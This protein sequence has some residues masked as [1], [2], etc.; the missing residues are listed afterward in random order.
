MRSARLAILPLLYAEMDRST[1][2]Q[3]RLVR[4]EEA[5]LM[6]NIP[7]WEVGTF[8]GEPVYHSIPKD[9]YVKPSL[10]ELVA[11]SNV[12]DYEAHIYRYVLT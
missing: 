12:K 3:M 9:E 5:D 4:D 7:S 6:K 1:L 11:H 8:F 2:K 10:E